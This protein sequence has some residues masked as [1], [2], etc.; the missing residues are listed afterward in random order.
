MIGKYLKA[1]LNLGRISNLPTVWSNVVHGLSVGM[2]VALLEPLRQEYPG[3][4][5]PIG[6]GDLGR[7]LDQAFLLLVGMSLLYTAGMVLND[8]CDVAIDK[9]DRPNRPIP[10]GRVTQREAFIGGVVMLALGWACTLVYPQAV[11]V[12]AGVLVAAILGYNLLHRW[13]WAGLVLMPVCRGLVIWLSAS[14]FMAGVG[15]DADLPRVL[16]SVLAITCYTLIITLIAWGEALPSM[17]KL[18][19]WIGVM[20]AGMALVDA[21]FVGLMGLWPMSVFCAG[22]AVL[23]LAG[24]RWIKGS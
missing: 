16:G 7:L 8:A 19:S 23:S 14:A 24:Q 17:G 1:W 13:R 22:C 5:P 21:L 3:Q 12:W 2:F 11:S 6:W 9:E 20:I 10:S 15:I 4:V 18:A